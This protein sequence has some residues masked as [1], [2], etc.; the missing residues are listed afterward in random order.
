MSGPME[1]LKLLVAGIFVPNKEW[2]QSPFLIKLYG[3][4]PL[5]LLLLWMFIY[6]FRVI[7]DGSC[8]SDWSILVQPLG[9]W[10][11]AWKVLSNLIGFPFWHSLL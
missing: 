3:F 7:F 10:V 9:C 4:A 2:V 11:S 1:G 5:H 8:P 6:P